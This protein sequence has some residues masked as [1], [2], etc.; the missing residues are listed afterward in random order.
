LLDIQLP[1]LDGWQVAAR[2]RERGHTNAKIVM[3]SASAIEEYRSAIAL[4]FHDA[5]IMKPVDLAR[6]TETVVGLLGLR[7]GKDGP[8]QVRKDSVEEAHIP[9]LFRHDLDA[10]V[11]N[12][13]IGYLKGLRLTLA[14]IAARDPDSQPFVN[15]MMGYVD[16]VDLRGLMARLERLSAHIS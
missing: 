3:V 7:V 11:L 2:L 1:D 13:E 9:I 12:C 8:A 16:N 4:P 15:Q 14:G 6:L 5:F 10:L